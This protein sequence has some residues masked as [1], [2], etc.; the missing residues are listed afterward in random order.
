MDT[1]LIIIIVGGLLFLI[2]KYV[3]IQPQTAKILNNITVICLTLFIII[4][5]GIWIFGP[6]P[7]IRIGH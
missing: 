7:H 5:F 1:T 2:N 3:S 6:A 4:I